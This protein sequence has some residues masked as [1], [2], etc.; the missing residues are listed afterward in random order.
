MLCQSFA[1]AGAGATQFFLE[2]PKVA[3]VGDNLEI[4]INLSTEIRY[5]SHLP[6]D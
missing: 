6:I 1:N 2:E 5:M 3:S 4:T